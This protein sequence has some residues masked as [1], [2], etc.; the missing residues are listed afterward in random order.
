MDVAGERAR[1]IRALTE[2]FDEAQATLS[3][4]DTER[5][6]YTDSGWKVKDLTAHVSAWEAEMLR[7][8][9]A[10]ADGSEYEVE[11]FTGDD[12]QNAIY[13]EQRKDVP[14]ETTRE[15]WTQ[16]RESIKTLMGALT[17]AQLEGEMLF[18]WHARGTPIKMIGSTVGHQ[19]EHLAHIQR[20]MSGDQP[21]RR[22]ALVEALEAS[23]RDAVGALEGIDPE[24]VIYADSGWKVKDLIAHV[25]AW[26]AEMYRSLEAF[27]TGRRLRHS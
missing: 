24:R 26:E 10:Y 25:A 18:P 5:V 13:Y 16:T 15:R 2:A 4:A 27:H 19:N 12:A 9:Q 3:A 11:G 23:L 22:V 7:S 17:D 14:F 20:A 21:D 1:L 8:L 6:V